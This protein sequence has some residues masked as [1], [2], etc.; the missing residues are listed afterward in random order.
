MAQPRDLLST[1]QYDDS[2]IA[3]LPESEFGRV[4]FARI[5]KWLK[6]ADEDF[7]LSLR[8][9]DEDCKQDFRFKA[10]FI[11]ALKRVLQEPDR[12]KKEYNISTK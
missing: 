9:C 3:A 1:K 2:L 6:E 8:V 4:F 11:A 12:A 7:F 10:G 5:T